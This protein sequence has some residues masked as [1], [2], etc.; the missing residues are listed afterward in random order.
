VSSIINAL[1]WV[2]PIAVGTLF[3]DP[4]MRLKLWTMLAMLMTASAILLPGVP[5][6]T[7]M[8]SGIVGGA[9]VVSFLVA[10]AFDIA[11]VAAAFV[12]TVCLGAIE[13]ARRF[14]ATKVAE[15]GMVEK[16]E[17][18]SLLLRE[19]EEGEADWLWQIDT[20]RRVRGVSP[21]FAYALGMDPAEI[22]G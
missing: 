20:A 17:V 8:F 10:G 15:A 3:L 12:L 9:A 13:G 4:E 21:R 2:L 7:L 1:A 11:L 16:S 19:Y 22:D 5:M 6:G 14:L 18:V